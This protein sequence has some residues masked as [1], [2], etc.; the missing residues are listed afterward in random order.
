[1]TVEE[2]IDE[3][4]KTFPNEEDVIVEFKVVGRPWNYLCEKAISTRSIQGP[5]DMDLPH[6]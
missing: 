5:N 1:M 2:F 3:V 4:K 6:E